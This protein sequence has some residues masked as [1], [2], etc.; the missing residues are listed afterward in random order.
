M[1]F[2]KAMKADSIVRFR[3]K[4]RQKPAIERPSLESAYCISRYLQIRY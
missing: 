4:F 2:V 1:N 3:L